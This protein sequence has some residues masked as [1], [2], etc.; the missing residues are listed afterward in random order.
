M[1]PIAFMN[2]FASHLIEIMGAVLVVAL[3]LRY[4]TYR[5]GIRD[6]LYFMTFCKS[7]ENL[8][9][10]DNEKKQ[11]RDVDSWMTE[12]IESVAAKLPNRNL[13]GVQ[14]ANKSTF[15]NKDKGNAESFS[16]FMQGRRSV[17]MAIKQQIDVF[18]SAHPPNFNE[19]TQRILGQD[20]KWTKLGGL[21][22]I[23]TL[24]RVFD[25]LPGL[26][27]VGGIFGTFIGVTSALPEIAKIDLSRLDEATPIINTFV[28]SVAYSMNTSISGIVYNVTMT[29]LNTIFP[30]ASQ[31]R[32]VHKALERSFELIW[33]RIHGTKMSPAEGRMI[34]LLEDLNQKIG[35]KVD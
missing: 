22:P 33:H 6:Q 32:E 26:F 19:L 31:R 17:V 11:I 28:A 3:V 24:S 21:L 35:K 1:S 2:L 13:R 7:V 4:L 30:I 34:E 9:A 25:I 15:R 29:L 18:K 27:I 12:F 10:S 20:E 8:L 23:S 16:E 14:G 5:S